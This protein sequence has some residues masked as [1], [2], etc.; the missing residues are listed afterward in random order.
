MFDVPKPLT[1]G[2]WTVH[3]TG[4]EF[5]IFEPDGNLRGR[6]ASSQVMAEHL[7]MAMQYADD[8][9]RRLNQAADLLDDIA[10]RVS[11]YTSA[12]WSGSDIIAAVADYYA[13][14]A[15]ELLNRMEKAA[16]GE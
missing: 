10:W 2:S 15:K 14:T 16:R 4:E 13:V 8:L 3:R 5:R 9:A 1:S 6:F 11:N 12:N 7:A